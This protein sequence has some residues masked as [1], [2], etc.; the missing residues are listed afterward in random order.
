MDESREELI[1]PDEANC[2]R[3]KISGGIMV[4]INQERY[5]RQILYLCGKGNVSISRF[6][7]R[8][9][10]GKRLQSGQMIYLLWAAKTAREIS[11]R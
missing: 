9:E 6:S 8:E 4:S 7:G 11:Q 3:K 5:T 1:I 10:R 2:E